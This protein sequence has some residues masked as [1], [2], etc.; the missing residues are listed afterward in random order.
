[1]QEVEGQIKTLRTDLLHNNTEKIDQGAGVVVESNTA[2][3]LFG[4]VSRVFELSNAFNVQKFTRMKLTLE[5]IDDVDIQG[6]GLC[7]YDRFPKRLSQDRCFSTET[8]GELD[9]DLGQIFYNKETS[10]SYISLFMKLS[11]VQFENSVEALV[12]TIS[13]SPGENTDIVDENGQCKDPNAR[14]IN[15]GGETVC[16]CMDGYVSSNGGKRQK[17]LDSCVGCLLSPFCGFEG[18]SCTTSDDC[19]RGSC[20]DG[21]CDRQWVSFFTLRSTLKI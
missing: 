15:D 14:T 1:M 3:R 10:V 17:E 13:V 21:R 19:Y 11:S 12:S 18:D 9:I 16:F 6:V 8:G 4:N 7:F 2:I 5:I 20:Q